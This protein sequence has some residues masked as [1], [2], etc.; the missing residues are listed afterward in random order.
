MSLD[1][2]MGSAHGL[3][4]CVAQSKQYERSSKTQFYKPN[5][6]QTN[7]WPLRMSQSHSYISPGWTER[8]TN[9]VCLWAIW[10]HPQM[11]PQMTK[12]II[13]TLNLVVSPA[14]S[15]K[16]VKSIIFE[17]VLL[18]HLTQ[19]LMWELFFFQ[20]SNMQ[21]LNTT[22]LSLAHTFRR[23]IQ[24]LICSRKLS[25]HTDRKIS[26]FKS[27]TCMI[28]LNRCRFH[29]CFK[30][31]HCRSSTHVEL[32]DFKAMWLLRDVVSLEPTFVLDIFLVL[33]DICF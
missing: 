29:F 24:S 11:H 23:G 19:T 6:L 14:W 13:K 31:N 27:F 21:D 26:N 16:E 28:A 32:E 20:K 17:V 15:L 18:F 4:Y 25:V 7:F 33:K 2:Q 30:C 9:Y 5:W 10:M 8:M 1:L 12:R 3:Q 22:N